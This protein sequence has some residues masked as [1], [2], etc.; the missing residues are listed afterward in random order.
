MDVKRLPNKCCE[1]DNFELTLN[2]FFPNAFKNF[3]AVGLQSLCEWHGSVVVGTVVS[4]QIG[5]GFESSNPF[6]CSV[7][8]LSLCLPV[9]YSKICMG[10]R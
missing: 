9:S 6:L 4:Q 3:L 1:V 8:M 10:L 7:Y 2:T 5:P